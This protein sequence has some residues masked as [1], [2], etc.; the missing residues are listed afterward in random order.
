MEPAFP[1]ERFDQDSGKKK[2]KVK[3]C[4]TQSPPDLTNE[5]YCYPPLGY[6]NQILLKYL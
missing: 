6:I 3:Y 1:K 4:L 5:A 2:P